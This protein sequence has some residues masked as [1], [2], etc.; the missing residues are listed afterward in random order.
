M[1]INILVVLI[2]LIYVFVVYNFL[3]QVYTAKLLNEED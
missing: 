1:E 2:A 3:I